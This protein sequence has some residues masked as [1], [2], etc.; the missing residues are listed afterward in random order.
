M[1]NHIR[2]DRSFIKGSEMI[3]H[4]REARRQAVED[5]KLISTSYH[6]APKSDDLLAL[7]LSR[8]AG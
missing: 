6:S 8:P 7:L 3:N 1:P 2:T 4:R 5:A